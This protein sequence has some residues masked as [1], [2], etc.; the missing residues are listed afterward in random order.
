V[1]KEGTDKRLRTAAVNA[2][3]QIGTEKARAALIDIIEK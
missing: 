1:V 3:G 2:L